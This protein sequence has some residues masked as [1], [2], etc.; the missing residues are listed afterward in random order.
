MPSARASVLVSWIVTLSVI[1]EIV[2][3]YKIVVEGNEEQ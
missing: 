1:A 3:K 2:T